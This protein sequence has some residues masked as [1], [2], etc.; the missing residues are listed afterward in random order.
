MQPHNGTLDVKQP[1]M[2][3]IPLAQINRRHP[4][5]APPIIAPVIPLDG[6]D[7]VLPD[8]FPAVLAEA[9]VD[10]E[11]AVVVVRLEVG[12]GRGRGPLV[13]RARAGGRAVPAAEFARAFGFVVE[14]GA[15]GD[16]AFDLCDG[17]LSVWVAR[18][19]GWGFWDCG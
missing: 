10:Q 3:P 17:V 6:L 11:I 14:G 13:D 5:P 4:R 12:R 19:G 8:V 16:Y 15:Q 18:D 9:D 7:P 2:Q 1:P